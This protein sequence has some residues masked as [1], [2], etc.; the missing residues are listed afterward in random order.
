MDVSCVGQYSLP[1]FGQYSPVILYTSLFRQQA[2]QAKN[3]KRKKI[4]I[5][6]TSVYDCM[7]ADKL[8]K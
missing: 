8:I 4:N 6:M 2:A 1:L 7:P 3:R 5:V